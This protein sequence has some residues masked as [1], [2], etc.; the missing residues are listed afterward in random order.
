[1]LGEG[2]DGGLGQQ[3]VNAALD[4]VQRNVKVCVVGREDGAEVAGP[5]RV[6]R[7]L[8]CRVR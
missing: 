3:S 4:G 8:V 1:V 6:K 5:Q 7:R 2:H